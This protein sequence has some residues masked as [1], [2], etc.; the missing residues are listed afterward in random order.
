MRTLAIV[1]LKG[2]SCKST[3]AVSL[4]ACLGEKGRR[5]LLVDLDPAGNATWWLG[6]AAERGTYDVLVKGLPLADAALPTT[7]RRVD[8]VPATEWLARAE[9]ELKDRQ[10]LQKALAAMKPGRW[11]YVLFDSPPSL[12]VLSVNALA[13][14]HEV[15]V[16]VVAHV[17]S[18]AGLKQLLQAVEL[19]RQQLNPGLKVAGL[20]ACRVNRTR[21]VRAIQEELRRF[22]G[23]LLLRTVIRENI[24]LAEA[25]SFR[26]PITIYAPDSLGAED[27]RQLAREILK[28]EGKA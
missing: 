26:Q 4:A 9:Y 14:A 8:I 25:P 21:H 20:L 18:L 7:A 16:P 23:D 1:N 11:D 13:A 5:V 28:Q 12:T 6:A 19:T 3:T 24:R 15:L 10:A 2:G 17:L 22:A 27:Y